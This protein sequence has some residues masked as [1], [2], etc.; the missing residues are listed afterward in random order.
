M[1]AKYGYYTDGYFSNN[2]SLDLPANG[3]LVKPKDDSNFVYKFKLGESIVKFTG[4]T[5][6][7]LQA[8]GTKGG[9]ING[10]YYLNGSLGTGLVDNLFYLNGFL[11]TGTSNGIYYR[12]GIPANGV[13]NNVYYV[14]GI[15]S[16][17]LVNNI[18][19]VNGPRGSGYP[20]GLSPT[21]VL[22]KNGNPYRG[23]IVSKDETN[24]L[25]PTLPNRQ[26]I[27]S[28]ITSNWVGYWSNKDENLTSVHQGLS[29]LESY[30]NLAGVP[31]TTI[32]VLSGGLPAN[33]IMFIPGEEIYSNG[34]LLSGE[35]VNNG[36]LFRNG[37]T[38]TGYRNVLDSTVTWNAQPVDISS[39]FVSSDIPVLSGSKFFASGRLAQGLVNTR[40]T[41]RG[42]TQEFPTYYVNGIK[43]EALNI[44]TSGLSGFRD[45]TLYFHK[46]VLAN[47]VIE[48]ITF[49][50]GVIKA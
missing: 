17:G 2:I 47:G 49:V 15:P 48:G 3:I 25:S 38:F 23:E 39:M 45:Q 19:Y 1:S 7:F 40:Y 10:A 43:H 13:F 41:T 4:R 16:T 11:R 33:G 14:E 9:G 37:Y 50:N 12:S 22:Y 29:S 18:Y 8:G 44:T 35:T 32:I 28:A 26:T 6:L 30:W 21:N 27:V 20:N 46:G 5:E 36:K 34:V 31:L 42:L 24:L